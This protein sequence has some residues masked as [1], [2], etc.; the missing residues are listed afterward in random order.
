MEAAGIHNAVVFVKKPYW[1]FYAPFFSH[2]SPT[3]DGDIVY[4]VDLG[5]RNQELMALYPGR[6]AYTY[7][8][9]RI[10]PLR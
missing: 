4:A 3:L 1:T 9:G 8:D 2:N 6:A 5:S 10:E 7:A